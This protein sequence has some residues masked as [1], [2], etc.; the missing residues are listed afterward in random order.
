MGSSA[1]AMRTKRRETLSD[2][3]RGRDDFD[4]DYTARA[5]AS[6]RVATRHV[7]HSNEESVG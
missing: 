7:S 2:L 1:E 3:G 5:R 4:R 6:T